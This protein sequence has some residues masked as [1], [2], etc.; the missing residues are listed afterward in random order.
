MNWLICNEPVGRG[1]QKHRKRRA[2]TESE[3]EVAD[4]VHHCGD[5]I[6]QANSHMRYVHAGTRSLDSHTLPLLT[7]TLTARDAE[8]HT[9]R[10]GSH[11]TREPG[12]APKPM[13]SHPTFYSDRHWPAAPF[14]PPSLSTYCILR[15]LGQLSSTSAE[16]VRPLQPP[17]L[18]PTNRTTHSFSIPLL[19]SYEGHTLAHGT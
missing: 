13:S 7:V 12:H 1:V 16:P 2:E 8:N 15:P 18:H 3:R 17:S 11:I 14:A 10:F 19:L 5:T 4:H 6:S 9:Q